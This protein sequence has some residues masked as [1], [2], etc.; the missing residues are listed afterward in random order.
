MKKGFVCAVLAATAAACAPPEEIEREVLAVINA[1]LYPVSGPPIENGTMLVRDG[2]I[3]DIGT[4]VPVPRGARTLDAHRWS[5]IPGLV[6]SHSHMGFK[7][8]NIPATGTNNNEL[9]VPINAQVRAI[10]GLNSN[11]AAFSLALASGVTTMN[12]T[13]GSR[14]PNSGQAVVVKLRG[15]TMEDMFL[16]EGGMKFAMRADRQFDNF[17]ETVDA[18][19]E[20]LVS[21][22]RAAEGYLEAR[23]AAEASG[24]QP[25]PR[26]LTREAF[27]KLLT[28]DWVVG[29][30]TGDALGMRHAIALKREFDLDLYIHHARNTDELVDE[31]VEAEVP[32]SFGPILPFMGRENPQI[33]GPVRLAQRGGTVAFHA[34][35]PDAHQYFLRPS[36]SLFVRKGMP[37]EEALAALT[38][39]PAKLFHLEDRIGSLEVGKDADFVILNGPPLDFESLVQQVFIDGREVFNRTTGENAFGQR[40]PEGW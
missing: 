39:N 25:P 29:V 8:L 16:A 27:G 37:E 31:L 6:E 15:G 40:V 3:A 20:L 9:S 4:D 28:R 34:D 14:S 36:A 17:P 24:S 30:H 32:I 26:D 33:M 10:D 12:I 13:T 19:Y 23:A 22:L 35:H 5:V 18:V 21:E 2:K 7:Q 11:D 38:L 1:H